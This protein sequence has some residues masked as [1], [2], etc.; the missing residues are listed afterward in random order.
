MNL[1]ILLK[2]LSFAGFVYSLC[3]WMP[4]RAQ[5]AQDFERAYHQDYQ[6][7]L[8]F[9]REHKILIK[10]TLNLPPEELKIIMAVVFPEVVRFSEVSN[11]LETASL[12]TLY[13]RF[14]A[15]Y[16]NFSIGRFQMKPSFVE[17][18]ELYVQKHRMRQH[19]DITHL[20]ASSA[21]AIRQ[22]RLRRMKDL[23][24][25]IR[26]LGA[27]YA[28]VKHKF[29][30]AW[31]DQESQIRFVAATYNRGFDHAEADI[32]S[33][34]TKRTF[35]FGPGYRGQQYAYTDIAY[36]VYVRYLPAIFD[37]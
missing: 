3:I 5:T 31:T 8:D 34:I 6:G 18:L 35:P 15:Q 29:P 37:E 33:W 30:Q 27:F 22:E 16:A 19:A 24:W 4:I 26:Y 36:D 10:S 2:K 12:E 11:L 23:S 9:L 28:V 14:G 20:E 1:S 13:T 32:Q 25:Q 7:A 21:R 17:S